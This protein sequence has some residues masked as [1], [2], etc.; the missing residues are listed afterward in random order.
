MHPSLNELTIGLFNDHPNQTQKSHEE[1]YRGNSYFN[2]LVA[3]SPENVEN[4]TQEQ[5]LSHIFGSDIKSVL[6]TDTTNDFHLEWSENSNVLRRYFSPVTILR[7]EKQR[8]YGDKITHF[9]V[10]K[11]GQL[12]YAVFEVSASDMA[13][14]FLMEVECEGY[15]AAA[16]ISIDSETVHMLCRVDATSLEQ[17]QDRCDMIL[18]VANELWNC[19]RSAWQVSFCSMPN[20]EKGN[21]LYL[22]PTVLWRIPIPT[23]D[24]A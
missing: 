1:S 23:S 12:K 7:S 14:M 18:R 19:N 20:L 16:I 8:L 9:D 2:G 24:F 13:D 11:H 10:F 4:C 5:F 21:L 3:I 22:N 17:Y 6:V 15:P